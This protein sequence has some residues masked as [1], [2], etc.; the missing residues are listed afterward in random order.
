MQISIA[1]VL[2]AVSSETR[3]EWSNAT[4]E[5]IDR[6]FKDYNALATPYARRKESLEKHVVNFRLNH[7]IIT[8]VNERD[9]TVSIL[10]TAF[11]NWKDPRL[12]WDPSEADDVAGISMKLDAVWIPDV[13]PI[14]SQRIDPVF[15]EIDNP[16]SLH[17]ANDGNVSMYTYHLVDFICEMKFDSFPFDSQHCTMGFA[18]DS[19]VGTGLTLVDSS[20]IT[21]EMI[22]SN[23]EWDIAGELTREEFRVEHGVMEIQ[24]VVFRF[25]VVRCSIFWLYLIVV[26]T[27]LFCIV[28]LVGIFFYE[29][30]DALANAAS[31]GLTTM[32]S[33]MLVVTI[34]SEAL[35]K[36][37]SLPGLGW[38]IFAEITVACLSVISLLILEMIRSGALKYVRMMEE[39]PVGSIVTFLI[40]KR[41]YRA[42]K[43]TLF[44][45][46]MVALVLNAMLNWSR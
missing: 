8:S 24:K 12:S 10:A 29:G 18:L 6:L 45:L 31:I 44:L 26:P 5:L 32:T 19:L 13:Y 3:A 9:W 2:L 38:F 17:I 33:L 39:R 43:F 34:L 4:A 21:A 22:K 42:A 37:D 15:K 11:Y 36:A 1:F 35:D 16:Q 40:N 25:T 41:V 27:M 14:R 28:T 7:A 23:S 20:Q 46:A 30:E